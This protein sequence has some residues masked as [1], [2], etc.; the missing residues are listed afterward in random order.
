MDGRPCSGSKHTT[1][2]RIVAAALWTRSAPRSK[3]GASSS[4]A[5]RTRAP[6]CACA[7]NPYRRWFKDPRGPDDGV[8]AL[9]RHSL[10]RPG[11]SQAASQPRR[12]QV[13]ISVY[14]LSVC[15]LPADLLPAFVRIFR[16]TIS[17]AARPL[18][19]LI[20]PARPIRPLDR[21][22]HVGRQLFLKAL[23]YSSRSLRRVQ[24]LG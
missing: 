18:H 15:P 16:V 9:R 19:P 11:H 14:G 12:S 8:H 20:T 7:G 6:A 4:S 23:C 10:E 22:E 1:A 21:A 24:S 13:I 2:F 3:P 17:A 5:I